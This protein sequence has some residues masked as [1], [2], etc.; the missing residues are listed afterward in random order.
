MICVIIYSNVKVSHNTNILV[1]SRPPVPEVMSGIV[2]EVTAVDDRMHGTLNETI[3]KTKENCLE[4]AYIPS[5]DLVRLQFTH[6]NPYTHRGL[7]FTSSI[8]LQ[9]YLS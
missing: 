7:S 1:D 5:K 2:E 4:E 3:E 9:I 8:K 6:R